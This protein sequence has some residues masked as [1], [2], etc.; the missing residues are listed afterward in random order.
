MEEGKSRRLYVRCIPT[1]A[2]VVESIPSGKC[3]SS[4]PLQQALK[5]WASI[6]VC[7]YVCVHAYVHRYTHTH[8]VELVNLTFPMEGNL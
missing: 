6:C 2:V 7:V 5:H 4:I 8:W 1:G 3:I